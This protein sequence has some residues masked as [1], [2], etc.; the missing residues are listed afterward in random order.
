M[1]ML[2][3]EEVVVLGHQG[4]ARLAQR[5]QSL[6]VAMLMEGL[7]RSKPRKGS[8]ATKALNGTQLMAAAAVGRVVLA[9]EVEREVLVVNTAAVVVEV[10]VER[11]LLAQE[12]RG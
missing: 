12:S 11:L 7:W 6:T 10:I 2:A 9:A 8:R 3:A 5:A 1:G 4:V